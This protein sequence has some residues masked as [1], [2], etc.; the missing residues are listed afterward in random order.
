M[1][2]LATYALGFVLPVTG[3]IQSLVSAHHGGHATTSTD[4]IAAEIVND[5]IPLAV[6]LFAAVLGM[7][8]ATRPPL[9]L[10]TED[11]G[12]RARPSITRARKGATTL[13]YAA[14]LIISVEL[15]QFILDAAHVSQ[16]SATG[17]ADQLPALLVDSGWAGL[18]EEPT[19]LG[20]TLGLA[21]RL[22]WRWYA[23]VPLMIAMRIA[24]HL[25]YGAGSVFVIFWMVAAY[26][27]YRGCPLLWPFIVGHGI[28]DVLQVLSD[29]SGARASTFT[30][31]E[32]AVVVAGLVLATPTLL[33][34]LRHRSLEPPS[35]PQPI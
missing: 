24:F 33:D 2:L 8:T 35:D 29:G 27:L 30:F 16:D 1:V 9:N 12:L 19:L 25:Y 20:L 21:T 28:F 22:R 17:T 26:V 5:A 31:V 7:R 18:L 13:V 3:A 6:S 32:I 14:A 10:T 34:Y 11:L 15:G 23:V 4:S